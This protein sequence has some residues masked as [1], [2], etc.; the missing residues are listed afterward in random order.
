MSTIR[1]FCFRT[2]AV[3]PLLAGL[4]LM[5]L[6]GVSQTS[7]PDSPTTASA[8]LRPDSAAEVTETTSTM[9]VSLFELPPDT[10]PVLPLAQRRPRV[11]TVPLLLSQLETPHTMAE[12][13]KDARDYQQEL[14]D[15]LFTTAPDEA[16]ERLWQR[17]LYIATYVPPSDL[18]REGVRKALQ[19]SDRMPEEFQR[20]AMEAAYGVDPRAFLVEMATVAD[21]TTDSKHFAM[22]TLYLSRALSDEAGTRRDS[23]QRLQ[24]RFPQWPSDPILTMLHF[25]LCREQGPA[26]QNASD[27]IT[28][29]CTA[30]TEAARM[31]PPLDDLFS[32]RFA[33]GYPVVYSLQRPDRSWPGLALVRRPDGRFHRNPDG[34]LFHITHLARSRTDLPG[35]ITNGNT[36][37]GIFSVQG[38]GRSRLLAIG[39]TP[40]LHL[41]L[42]NETSPARWFHNPALGQTEWRQE[43]YRQ[44]LPEP[45]PSESATAPMAAPLS[46]RDYFPFYTAWYA[47]AAGRYDI[48]AHGTTVDLSRYIGRSWFPNAP[49]SG[50]LCAKELWD[51]ET[52]H[53]LVSDQLALVHAWL[54]ASGIR[55]PREEGQGVLTLQDKGPGGFLAVVEL[56][57]KPQPVTLD[58]ALT[59]ILAAERLSRRH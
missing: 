17:A 52:G 46:W 10:P 28:T 6:S 12:L 48:L 24:E 4:C 14:M 7:V 9:P 57:N 25:D 43:L 32:T 8:P 58:E 1:P 36:P 26:A 42:P 18:S 47:G 34:T 40:Y 50:C 45:A 35:Y 51:E 37:Q 23:L 21:T 5:P 38:L 3:L 20:M 39:E 27:P 33:P 41:F 29:A 56:D 22:A 19:A 54:E 31:R 2:V 44:L 49:T 55:V 15:D 16:R 59:D 13:R 53:A 30:A 11:T